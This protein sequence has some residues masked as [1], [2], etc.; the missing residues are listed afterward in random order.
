MSL[1]LLQYRL[2]AILLRQQV[3][4][5]IQELQRVQQKGLLQQCAASAVQQTV[6][7]LPDVFHVSV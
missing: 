7:Q 5:I 3:G 2:G 4:S 6:Q 1:V